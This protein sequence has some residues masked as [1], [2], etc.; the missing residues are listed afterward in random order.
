MNKITPPKI[1]SRNLYLTCLRALRKDSEEN[2]LKMR[3]VFNEINLELNE[4]LSRKNAPDFHLFTPCRHGHGDDVICGEVSK[5]NLVSLYT[6]YMLKSGTKAKDIYDA[7]SVASNG[8]CP[9]C[10]VTSV[11]TLD[12]YLPKARYPIFSVMPEN[13]VPACSDCNKGKGSSI[14]RTKEE[15]CLHPYYSERVFYED[16]W[17]K[18]RLKKTTP[19]TFDFFVSAP[20][21]WSD[22]NKE[23]AKNHFKDFKINKKYS[24]YAATL[25]TMLIATTRQLLRENTPEIVQEHF[26]SI[27]DGERPN[28]VIQAVYNAVAADIDFCS[29][30]F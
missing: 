19:I 16:V 3:A 29:G 21:H 1:K 10:G 18:A 25:V 20:E 2:Y 5:D 15:Q 8:I 30:H 14:L 9:L 11:S 26:K 24:I 7:I 22:L 4:Y 23:R 13:L 28:T 12:H 6:K 17:I 27:A